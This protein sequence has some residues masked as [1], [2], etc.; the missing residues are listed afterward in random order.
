MRSIRFFCC[1]RSPPGLFWE[2]SSG[3][4]TRPTTDVVVSVGAAQKGDVACRQ[5]SGHFM[6]I[7]IATEK[8]KAG[9]RH[10]VICPNVPGRT[11]KRIARSTR[12]RAGLLALVDSPQVARTCI[13][14]AFG[15]QM[16]WRLSLVLRLFLKKNQNTPRPSEHPP[17]M[18]GKMS[19][20]LGGIKGCKYKTSSWHLNK[21]P[22][23]DNIGST[24]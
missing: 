7:W 21:F 11:K 2:P 16:S 6:E 20:R 1:C 13:L 8:A 22:D 3:S 18:G 4:Y 17:V 14:R 12:A 15:L 9:L 10:A 19:T 23:A 24:V 5:G